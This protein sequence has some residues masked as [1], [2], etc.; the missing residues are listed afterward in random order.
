MHLLVLSAFRLGASMWWRD[1]RV[2][3]CTFWCSVLSDARDLLKQGR[4]IKRSQCT[5]WCS[6]L[7][8]N[9]RRYIPD[10]PYQA[11]SMHLLVLSAFRLE[12]TGKKA[13]GAH[14]VSMHLLVLSAFRH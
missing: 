5:F 9:I 11:V 8:D 1:I 6:V 12:Q 10:T 14:R 13:A 4:L 2:S 7:S 3:Q